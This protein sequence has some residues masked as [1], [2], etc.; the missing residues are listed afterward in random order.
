MMQNGHIMG[1]FRGV[2]MCYL[3]INPHVCEKVSCADE[4]TYY[5]GV[6]VSHVD[7]S[8]CQVMRECG[9]LKYFYGQTS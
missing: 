3:L 5:F 4:R 8:F 7:D 2:M 1:H 9:G 6:I